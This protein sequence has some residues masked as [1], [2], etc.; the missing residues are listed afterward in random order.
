ME[1]KKRN[2]GQPP[3]LEQPSGEKHSAEANP[4]SEEK[5]TESAANSLSEEQ[6]ETSSSSQNPEPHV[7]QDKTQLDEEAENSTSSETVEPKEEFSVSADERIFNTVELKALDQ[8][9]TE[10]ESNEQTEE[11]LAK[12]KEL[13]EESQAT[14]KDDQKKTEDSQ[15]FKTD[16]TVNQPENNS[17]DV[18][19]KDD[20][21]FNTA[22]LTVFTQLNTNKGQTTTAVQATDEDSSTEKKH[23]PFVIAKQKLG[24]LGRKKVL[25][26]AVAAS[27]I[28]VGGFGIGTYASSEDPKQNK[29]IATTPPKPQPAKFQLYLDDKKFE[30]DLLQLGYNGKDT[31]TIDEQKIRL[32]LDE[33]KKQVDQPAENAKQKRF[34][35]EITPE[36]VGRKMDVKTVNS[37][38]SDLKPY[39]NKPQEIPTIPV[40]PLITTEDLKQVD[41]K[42]IGDYRTRFDGSNHNRTTNI[43]LASKEINNLILMPG[44]EFSFNRVVGQRTAERGYKPAAVIVKGEYSE[45]IGGGICQVSS[46][47]YNSVDEAGL[48]I[49]RR[50]SH[51]KEVTYVPP[52]RDATVSWGGP[53]FRFKNN[54]DK[55]ILIKIKV[56]A[57][58]MVVYTYT[59]PGA[60]VNK[61]KVEEAPETFTTIAVDPTKPTDNL[62]KEQNDN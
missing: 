58:S 28:L 45:G 62:Q 24:Q 18:L 61:K 7:A 35:G 60:K 47:L 12:A 57:N 23:S 53:D 17:A 34:G 6:V 30:L 42:L 15:Q 10:K 37:W 52:G 1:E 36:K 5:Q 9:G 41:K 21:A 46:T 22:E 26:G 38:L 40:E 16:S 51:S 50:I 11:S 20:R 2:E 13:T 32:W 31:S 29:V 3:E 59:V 44:E 54:L 14:E 33:V 56:Q 27:I 25:I 48:K 4:S 39:I 19:P 8:W 49:T 43:R 55:P